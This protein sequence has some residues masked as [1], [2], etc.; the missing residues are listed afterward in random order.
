MK[1]IPGALW[2][3]FLLQKI[4]KDSQSPYDSSPTR[5]PAKCFVGKLYIHLIFRHN[6][7]TMF[8]YPVELTW[9]KDLKKARAK[10][11][12]QNSSEVAFPV[13]EERRQVRRFPPNQRGFRGPEKSIPS[14]GNYGDARRI[15]TGSSSS[16]GRGYRDNGRDRRSIDRRSLDRRSMDRR[17]TD[18][19]ST[20]RRSVSRSRS[21]TG[22][23][24]RSASNSGRSRSRSV[25]RT[26]HSLPSNPGDS[27]HAS[28]SEFNGHAY[29]DRRASRNLSRRS[30]DG[31]SSSSRSSE[32]RKRQGSSK[33]S[34]S[35]SERNL[36]YSNAP[37]PNP[38]DGSSLGFE[39]ASVRDGSFSR[40]T[41]HSSENSSSGA[42]VASSN[43]AFDSPRNRSGR[44]RVHS[45][46]PPYN[47]VRNRTS[48]AKAEAASNSDEKDQPAVESQKRRKT[49]NAHSPANNSTESLSEPPHTR[50]KTQ[51]T[52]LQKTSRTENSTTIR[53]ANA[54][55]KQRPSAA[56]A[57]KKSTTKD[58]PP[59]IEKS[60][61]KNSHNSRRS[62]T[63][64]SPLSLTSRE[65]KRW[66]TPEDEVNDDHLHKE[67][68]WPSTI[69]KLA[70]LKKK[71]AIS[72]ANN[73]SDNDHS[74]TSKVDG[75][76]VTISRNNNVTAK[77]SL[78]PLFKK[79][80]SSS[81]NNNQSV[82]VGSASSVNNEEN[83]SGDC[84]D[85]V[86]NL[87]RDRKDALAED[88]KR[89]CEAFTTVVRMLISKDQD[90]ESRLMP[91]LKEI[92]HERGQ[93]CI[94]DLRTFISDHQVN[95]SNM[96]E[97][98]EKNHID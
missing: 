34:P 12:L 41:R 1:Q 52:S 55:R 3:F 11:N 13:Y 24:S 19:R 77:E 95:E 82:T 67:E 57:N 42:S 88:Y 49:R 2:S 22:S 56:K 79:S 78:K 40:R 89:D 39:Q 14:P 50:S 70:K 63:A 32:G 29:D 87:I 30:H 85:D 51:R 73:S 9:F 44:K 48:K 96:N 20:E 71:S 17:S 7:K 26:R 21:F 43:G 84:S 16:G 6:G 94:E 36:A 18:R 8:G 76:Q 93:R 47:D 80:S 15:R 10:S 74:D 54:D 45:I 92:L 62:D 72:S 98:K 81:N 4:R 5:L 23:S 97:F 86:M 68:K 90:L 38:E 64:R 60:T 59:T 58:S 25:S 35:V 31:S 91:M 69:N 61:S 33:R 28:E 75:N 66:R 83:E 65:T 53:Q 37:A 27:M 46:S